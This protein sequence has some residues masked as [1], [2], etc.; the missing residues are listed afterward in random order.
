MQCSC[1][2]GSRDERILIFQHLIYIRKILAYPYQIFIRKFPK[3]SIRLS[4][5]IRIR[6]WLKT[7][8]TS[9]GYRSASGP[10]FLKTYLSTSCNV[11]LTHDKCAVHCTKL[12]RNVVLFQS[13]SPASAQSFTL[14]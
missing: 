9:C 13:E 5:R 12:S 1:S 11:T 8:Q 14:W 3:F 10:S 2:S 7:K 4:I 6:H